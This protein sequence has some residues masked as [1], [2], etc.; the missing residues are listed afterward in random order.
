MKKL[1]LSL[2]FIV[3]FFNLSNAQ[4]RNNGG[5][6]QMDPKV[7]VKNLDKQLNLTDSQEQSILQLYTEFFK[8]NKN[9]REKNKRE[10]ER[11]KRDTLN[12]K[13]KALLT[14]EQ[15]VKFEE[16]LKRRAPQNKGHRERPNNK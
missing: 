7:I 15:A 12:N 10:E 16:I 13:I 6:P 8:E 5:R 11:L 1:I 4:Q 14:K 2:V 3:A 9:S